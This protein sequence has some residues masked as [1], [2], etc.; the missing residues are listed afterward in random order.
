[1][2]AK[3][4]SNKAAAL[5]FL[6]LVTSGHVRQAYDDHVGPTFKHHNPYFPQGAAALMGGMEAN[7]KEMPNKV[8]QVLR[9]IAEGELV[10][11]H[12]S[13]RMKATEPAMAVVHIFRFE[14]G[15]VLELWDIAQLA[16][17]SS[18]NEDG[19]F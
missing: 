1:M 4:A 15:Q 9:A 19:M 10:F 11:V 13:L 6:R 2:A 14:R 8:F 16:P 3:Q 12:S 7:A 17:A 5:E 18:P